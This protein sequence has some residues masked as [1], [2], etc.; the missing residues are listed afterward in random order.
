M[1]SS[2]KKFIKVCQGV[3]A[4]TMSKYVT[5]T[6]I[7]PVMDDSYHVLQKCFTKFKMISYE[8][9]CCQAIVCVG[10][11]LSWKRLLIQ[12]WEEKFCPTFKTVITISGLFNLNFWLSNSLSLYLTHTLLSLLLLFRHWLENDVTNY[13]SK[14]K[15]SKLDSLWDIFNLND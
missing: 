15:T 7:T 8:T 9:V 4:N 12:F 11:F 10:F 2:S 3:L 6:Y 5:P 13:I 14:L 1:K